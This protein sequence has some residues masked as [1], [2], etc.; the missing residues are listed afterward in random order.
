MPALPQEQFG[1]PLGHHVP[2]R[3][4]E[5]GQAPALPHAG[6]DTSFILGCTQRRTRS[7][8]AVTD[9]HPT[10]E[11]AHPGPRAN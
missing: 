8:V 1:L 10:E 6:R 5:R 4:A 9:H 11:V 3:Q 7:T 2:D